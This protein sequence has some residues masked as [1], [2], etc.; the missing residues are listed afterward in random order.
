MNTAVQ[1]AQ[2]ARSIEKSNISVI[3]ANWRETS[4]IEGRGGGEEVLHTDDLIANVLFSKVF[5]KV[6]KVIITV[7]ILLSM[8]D[9]YSHSRSFE[10]FSQS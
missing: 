10:R 3:N 5:H 6:R 7:S 1:A 9:T 8:A 4:T 2:A